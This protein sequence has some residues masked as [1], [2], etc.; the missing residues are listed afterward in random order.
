[1]MNEFLHLVKYI[2]FFSQPHPLLYSRVCIEVL[3]KRFLMNVY[4]WCQ[5]LSLTLSW[6][7]DFKAKPLTGPGFQEEVTRGCKSGQSDSKFP[8]TKFSGLVFSCLQTTQGFVHPCPLPRTCTD[9]KEIFE[10]LLGIN[11]QPS[12]ITKIGFLPRPHP[13]NAHPGSP[14][15]PSFPHQKSPNWP[16]LTLFVLPSNSSIF[17]SLCLQDTPPSCHFL[18]RACFPGQQFHLPRLCRSHLGLVPCPRTDLPVSLES[19]VMPWE[20]T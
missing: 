4:R 2:L 19:T 16:V 20:A 7:S 15:F 5:N 14:D 1:M 10:H 3:F 9:H 6:W 13:R 12:L 8:Y 17:L 11:S 18:I